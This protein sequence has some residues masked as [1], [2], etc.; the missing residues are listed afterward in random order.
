VTETISGVLVVD[1][2]AGPTSHDVVQR[3]R[4]TLGVRRVGHAGTLDPAA[5]GVLVVLV[6]EAT[7]LEPYFSA[8]DKA[9]LADVLLGRSTDTLD[10]E[11]AT[12]AE[13]A[14]SPELEAELQAKELDAS[15]A[16][17]LLEEAL[18]VERSRAQQ[19]PPAYSAI[20]VAGRRSHAEA[21][22]GRAPE[23][24][25]RSVRAHE[26]ELVGVQYVGARPVV[27]VRLFVSKG[28]YVRSFARDL[29]SSLGLPAMLAGLRRTHSGPFGLEGSTAPDEER[30]TLIDR[31][32]PV[33]RAA[34]RLLPCRALTAQG[35][36]KA[37]QGK[38]L[39]WTAD[40]EGPPVDL[41]A[42]LALTEPEGGALVAIAL[43]E[44][45]PADPEPADPEPADPEKGAEPAIFAPIRVVRGFV[46][47]G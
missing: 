33:E 23:L 2:P 45:P 26:V 13:G 38:R 4:R 3:L 42:H 12:V 7:K 8:C 20:K 34:G 5:T 40:V 30:A 6:G 9:Y 15:A 14:P 10:L 25:P 24:P 29:G 11:G 35:A 28:Y 47:A 36:L 46:T 17:P 41:G 37:R 44:A 43:V 39:S 21:R 31:L 1:K 32:I 22:A 27:T 18:Q 16:T 19:V